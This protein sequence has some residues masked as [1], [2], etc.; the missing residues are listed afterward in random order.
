MIMPRS[1]LIVL[2]ALAAACAPDVPQTP[3]PSAVTT[4]VFDPIAGNVPLPN[5]LARLPRPAGSPPFPPAQQELIDLFKS[6]VGF[7][8]YQEMPVT[9]TLVLTVLTAAADTTKQ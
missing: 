8:S 6:Q 5:D 4:A 3:A 9:I 2:L 7:L 1:R